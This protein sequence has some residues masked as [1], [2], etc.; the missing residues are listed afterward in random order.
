MQRCTLCVLHDDAKFVAGGL[1]EFLEL[2]DVRVLQDAVKLSLSQSG[3]AL[4]GRQVADVYALHH[5]LE[6]VLGR[7]HQVG[8][9]HGAFTQHS[10]FLVFFSLAATFDHLR[11]VFAVLHYLNYH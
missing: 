9:A 3:L 11:Q 8:L 7:S 2:H 6:A 10:H 5:V 4:L 1:V